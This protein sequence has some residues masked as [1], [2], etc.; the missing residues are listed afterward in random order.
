MRVSLIIFFCGIFLVVALHDWMIGPALSMAEATVQQ[1][2]TPKGAL[3]IHSIHSMNIHSMSQHLSTKSPLDYY[4]SKV[5]KSSQSILPV[6]TDPRGLPPKIGTHPKACPHSPEQEKACL[7]RQEQ[8]T[9]RC[10]DEARR[11][12]KD[13]KPCLM[14]HKWLKNRCKEC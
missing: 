10:L 14:R 7:T 2:E 12:R 13:P 6:L 5:M 4:A 11:N 9:Q 1:H 3:P 8:R